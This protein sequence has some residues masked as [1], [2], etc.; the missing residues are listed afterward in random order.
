MASQFSLLILILFLFNL[1]S[2]HV[3]GDQ[4]MLEDGYMV[5]TV[6]DG[7][8]LNINPHAVQLRSSDIVV[9]D[10]SHSVFYTLPFPIS[11]A[12]V[13]V[14][15]LSG[16]GKTGYID[17]EP[18]LARF[19]KPKS[20]AVDLRG[21]VYV[22]DQQNHAVRKISNSGVTSTIVGNYSQ[23]GRQD[24]P[25]KTATFS[26][27][28]EVLFV[29]QICALLISDHGNQLLRQIDLKPED[30]VIGSQSALG[31]VKFWVLGLALSCLL[32]IVM[33]IATRPYVIPH[34]GS[35]PLHFSKTWKH[36][37]INL[38]SLVR[39]SCFGVRNAIASSS[40]YMLSKRLLRLSLSHLSLMFQ[41]NTVGP[42]VSNKDFISINNPVISRSQTFADQLKEMIDSN[43]HSQLS[44]LSSDILKL[45]EGGLERCDASSDGNGRI[46]DMIQAN[47]TGFGK[48]AKETTPVD[49]PLE[50][51]LGLV[52]RR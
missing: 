16:E 49:V 44:S 25:G 52:K 30:C 5:T 39:M 50:G 12:S 31:A 48:L 45:G 28:F 17:G 29:P 3:T 7:H 11:Q 46:N 13:M 4:I 33:G 36:C 27:D 43:V 6:L 19:N 42:K 26:S 1:A 38:A 10:S 23:T 47:I 24:G 35:R 9:L 41:I 51:S 22:A 15:R 40:L 32:G 21:N 18:G 37:L 8:K 14:K 34:E 2:I 20:F